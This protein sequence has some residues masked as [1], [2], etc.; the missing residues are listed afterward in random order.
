MLVF[1]SDLH[2]TD[3]S[4]GVQH[5]DIGAF[6]EAFHNI[7]RQAQHAKSKEITF[8]FLGDIFDLVRTTFWFNKPARERPWG[9]GN[10]A[11]DAEKA[12]LQKHA[13]ELLENI[14]AE[15]KDIFDVWSQPL[16]GQYGLT[17]EPK[18]VYIPGNHD[19]I[20]NEF[21]TLRER[22]IEALGLSIGQNAP[23]DAGVPFANHFHHALYQ[24]FARHGHE[25]D[26]YNFEHVRDWS[27]ANTATLPGAHFLEIPIGELIAAEVASR[28]PTEACQH[29]KEQINDDDLQLIVEHMKTVDDVRPM[30][31]I[32]PWL[33]DSISSQKAMNK[34]ANRQIVLKA[35]TKS[36]Q[37]VMREFNTLPFTKAWM[38]KHDGFAP[39]DYV[40]RLQLGILALQ[41]LDVHKLN[42][43]LQ[44]AQ[45]RPIHALEAMLRMMPCL[46]KALANDNCASAASDDLKRI[47]DD[48]RFQNTLYL[49]YG[50]THRAEQVPLATHESSA[51]QVYL[52][53]GTWRPLYRQ[54]V[55]K[56]G[57]MR[58][59]NMTFTMFYNHEHDPEKVEPNDDPIFETWTGSLLEPLKSEKPELPC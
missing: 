43:L 31:A 20:C 38:K 13:R 33:V 54:A 40:D 24:V 34:P 55:S 26:E 29:L 11:T 42:R 4:T 32:L 6:K 49:L 51:C 35:L 10:D 37:K 53:T 2:I 21:S 16:K 52:N 46:D 25:W 50:H 39:L 17:I 7:A 56:T 44:M 18:R 12:A 19:R 47:N 23:L 1:L 58:W 57:F 28:L 9:I 14:I 36:I 27:N 5:L 48:V 15:N 59:K 45:S 3:K 8:V 41:N 30:A 22:V